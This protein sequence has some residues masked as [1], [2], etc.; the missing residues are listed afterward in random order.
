LRPPEAL[1]QANRE[2]IAG[3]ASA[4]G[5]PLAIVGSSRALPTTGL[6]AYGPP[7]REYARVTAKYVDRIFKGAKP[8]DLPIEQ[9][10]RFSLAINLKAARALGLAIPQ[11]MLLV[12]D[13]LIQ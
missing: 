2:E 5:L 11:S 13:E 12:A 1:I 10:I 6:F 4:L 3:F 7:L 9:P 8:G